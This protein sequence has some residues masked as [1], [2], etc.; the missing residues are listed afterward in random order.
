MSD[1]MHIWNI[2]FLQV[3]FILLKQDITNLFID[4]LI[5]DC[6]I[7]SYNCNILPLNSTSMNSTLIFE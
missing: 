1:R 5:F 4:V 3:N 7:L 6:L 2:F